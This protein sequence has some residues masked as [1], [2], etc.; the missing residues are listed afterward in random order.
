MINGQTK[1]ESI[2]QT[3]TAV[4]LFKPLES[5]FSCQG[6]DVAF[7]QYLYTFAYWTLHLLPLTNV[8]RCFYASSHYII[9]MTFSL[10]CTVQAFYN[11]SYFYP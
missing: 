11:Q 6:L 9:F 5:L 3:Q 8:F 2:Q 1:T 10:G 7:G 4:E